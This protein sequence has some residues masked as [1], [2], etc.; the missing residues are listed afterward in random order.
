M[1][2][3]SSDSLMCTLPASMYLIQA[4]LQMMHAPQ[5]RGISGLQ[6]QLQRWTVPNWHVS[7]DS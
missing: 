5:S 3:G 6:M 4:S 7:W 2:L 1:L